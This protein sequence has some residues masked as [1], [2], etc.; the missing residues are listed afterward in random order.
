[1]GRNSLRFGVKIIFMNMF[2]DTKELKEGEK[3]M[4]KSI[5][6]PDNI[7]DVLE[8]HKIDTGRPVSGMI[9]EAIWRWAIHEKLI[10]IRIVV[11]KREKTAKKINKMPE[12]LKFCNGPKCND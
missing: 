2:Q 10:K 8:Q 9:Q 11:I 12:E 4:K 1:M 6:I 3:K 7:S 5:E